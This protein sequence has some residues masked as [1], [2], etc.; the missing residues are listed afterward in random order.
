VIIYNTFWIPGKPPSLNDLN[1][2]RAIQGPPRSSMILR[3]SPGKKK[4]N[5]YT[6][7]K[8]NDEKQKW[9]KIVFD[10]VKKTGFKFTESC[11]YSYLVVEKT[12]KR[13]PSNICSSSIK[14]IEDGLMKA[15]VIPN[16]GWQNVLS[17]RPEWI[18]NRKGQPGILI[19]MSSERLNLV[20]IVDMYIDSLDIVHRQSALKN[21]IKREITIV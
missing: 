3:R 12:V 18:L 16:D 8:Y 4:K 7:N 14:F 20:T 11:H 21:L 13:D 9:S 1:A 2:F 10:V 17:I 6:F 15:G 5:T 19:V